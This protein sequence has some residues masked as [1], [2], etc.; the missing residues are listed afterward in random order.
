MLEW[1]RE[2]ANRLLGSRDA[3]AETGVEIGERRGGIWNRQTS[4]RG[5]TSRGST[6]AFKHFLREFRSRNDKAL[7]EHTPGPRVA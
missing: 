1:A 5:P 4:P 2:A 7:H 3:G 6:L